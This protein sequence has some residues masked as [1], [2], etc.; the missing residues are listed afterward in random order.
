[1]KKGDSKGYYE[2]LGVSPSATMAEIKK[3]YREK[4]R[5][6]HPDKNPTR[7]TTRHFQHLQEAYHVLKD[8]KLRSQYD[9]LNH[10]VHFQHAHPNQNPRAKQAHPFPKDKPIKCSKC[11]SV[12][13]QPRYVIFL[14]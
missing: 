10:N 4:A 1:M 6:L 3:A 11:S 13:A 5:E 2:I 8:P 9:A 12:S 14:L 7:D